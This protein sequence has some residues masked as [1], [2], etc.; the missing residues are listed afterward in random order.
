MI[1]KG[2]LVRLFVMTAFAQLQQTPK[3]PHHR[4]GWYGDFY[5]SL[6]FFG[7]T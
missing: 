6:Y 1:G 5:A 7:E 4:F 2:K 3:S